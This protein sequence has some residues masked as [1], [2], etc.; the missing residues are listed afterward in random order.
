LTPPQSPQPQGVRSNMPGEIQTDGGTSPSLSPEE[1]RA[2]ILATQRVYGQE[3]GEVGTTCY[4]VSAKWWRAW[5][6]YTG[7][8][9]NEATPAA[10]L[11][12]G[13]YSPF[14]GGAVRGAERPGPITNEDILDEET[15]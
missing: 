6:G 14:R 15:D 13:A 3:L 11:G 8:D 10:D 2:Q 5:R 7:Y 12:S 9:P 4:V 1:E